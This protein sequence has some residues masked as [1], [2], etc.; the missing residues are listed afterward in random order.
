[1]ATRQQL[2]A[3]PWWDRE[4]VTSP[5]VGLGL[6]L[7]TAYNAG[8]G[9]VGIKG[10]EVHLSGGHRSQ[11]WIKNSRYCENRTYTVQGSLAG[12]Q[13]R[14]C[15]ALDF[16]P[17]IWGTPDNRRKMIVLTRRAIDAMKAG[18]IPEL[19]EVF[20]TLDGVHVT[21]WRNDLNVVVTSDSSHL[22]HEHLRFDRRYCN[23]NAVMSKMAAILL[24]DDMAITDADAN[25]V[26]DKTWFRDVNT[27]SSEP[28]KTAWATLDDAYDNTNTIKTEVA[29][30]K[31]DVAAILDLLRNG[32]G[33]GGST[34]APLPT[35]GSF[36][37]SW[38]PGTAGQ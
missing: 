30:L 7:R 34:P 2:E 25:L 38:P 19:I 33:S 3:E 31:L 16:A 37:L 35:S 14:Y 13:W 9:S 18:Q 6:R 32:G 20:G 5:M 23:D 8:S 10:N 21:G 1:M 22:D 26:A 28:A 11:E 4:I 17:G 36:T 12:D 24:G 27:E 29:Q 15:S